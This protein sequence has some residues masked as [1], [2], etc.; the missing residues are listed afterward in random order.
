MTIDQELLTKAKTAGVKVA[1]ADKQA[2]L[3]KA[4]YHTVIRRLHL[5]GGS[6]REV[7]EALGIS[8]QRVQQM[9]QGAGGT[10]WQKVWKSRTVKRD[11]VCT[12]CQKPPSEVAKL[13]AGPNVYI[14]DSCVSLA[15]KTL[16]GKG[17]GALALAAESSKTSCSFCGKRNGGERQVVSGEAANI[18]NQCLELARQFVD[19]RS[20]K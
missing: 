11:A 10:W 17:Q 14:C 18:C 3:A 15:E 2:M 5:A 7:A 16:K 20:A 19:E 1:E 6:L 8:H 4:E 12:F 13:V 9:V